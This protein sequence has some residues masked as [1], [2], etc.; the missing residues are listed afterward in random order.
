MVSGRATLVED[1]SDDRTPFT[2][3]LGRI[4]AAVA[5]TSG[6]NAVESILPAVLPVRARRTQRGVEILWIASIFCSA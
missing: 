3:L 5:G 1:D 2:I 4:S 6:K